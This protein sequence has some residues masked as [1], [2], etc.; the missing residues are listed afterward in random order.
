[1]KNNKITKRNWCCVIWFFLFPRYIWKIVKPSF[2]R[3]RKMDKNLLSFFLCISVKL[4]WS[5]RFWVERNAIFFSFLS[6]KALFLLYRRSDIMKRLEETSCAFC[7]PINTYIESKLKISIPNRV[8]LRSFF[9][10][11]VTFSNWLKMW[12]CKRLHLFNFTGLRTRWS[13]VLR[14]KICTIPVGRTRKLL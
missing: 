3:D 6:Q 10:K 9:Q 12:L 14:E 7:F 1:M 11:N 8:F 2:L 4:F 13:H 5:L